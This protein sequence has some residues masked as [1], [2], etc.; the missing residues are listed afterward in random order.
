V[1]VLVCVCV[2]VRAIRA[3]HALAVSALGLT[4]GRQGA[5]MEAEID[6]LATE[7]RSVRAAIEV[8]QVCLCVLRCAVSLARTRASLSRVLVLHL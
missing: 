1:F 4:V 2:C 3:P 7:I 6:K 5:A 8:K